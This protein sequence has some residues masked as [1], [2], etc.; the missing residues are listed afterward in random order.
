MLDK[1]CKAFLLVI[2]NLLDILFWIFIIISQATAVAC[3]LMSFSVL[4][5]GYE[6]YGP[7]IFWYFAQILIFAANVASSPPSNM[8]NSNILHFFQLIG[9]PNGTGYQLWKQ[10]NERADE[11]SKRSLT[12]WI[13]VIASLIVFTIFPA[14]ISKLKTLGSNY[15]KAPIWRIFVNNGSY[16]HPFKYY[17]VFRFYLQVLTL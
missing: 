3:S 2:T 1:Y 17:D 9:C 11:S 4:F 7:Y 10:I 16:L 14:V 12:M 5:L 15:F 13:P 6:N 8:P